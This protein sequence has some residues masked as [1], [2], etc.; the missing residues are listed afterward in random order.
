MVW[1]HQ[2]LKLFHSCDIQKGDIFIIIQHTH[3][4]VSYRYFFCKNW[5][6]LLRE[7]RSLDVI[8]VRGYQQYDWNHSTNTNVN[9]SLV[10]MYSV[11]GITH[12]GY[13]IFNENFCIY[14]H[15]VLL[16]LGLHVCCGWSFS[17]CFVDTDYCRA[18][19]SLLELM[20]KQLLP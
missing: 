9:T 20:H 18:L 19:K 14:I 15:Y 10:P 13:H 6:E 3:K 7:K 17:N 1:I 2:I 8:E 12:V 5:D 4:P 11:R 16:L